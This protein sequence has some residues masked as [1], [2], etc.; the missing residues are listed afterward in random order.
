MFESLAKTDFLD[1]LSF[2]LLTGLLFAIVF[3]RYLFISGVFHFVFYWA[4]RNEFENRLINGDIKNKSQ[5][6]SEIKWS[7][8]TSFLFAVSGTVMVILWQSDN[9]ALYI[10]INEYPLWYLPISLTIALFLHETYYYWL[11]RWMH[12]PKVYRVMHKVHH[13][14]VET[15]SLTSFSFHPLESVLQAIIIP[16]IVFLLPMNIYVLLVILVIMTISGTLNHAGVELYPH[17]FHK[18]W[19]GKWLI[20]ATHHDLHH[21]KFRCNYGL[22]FTFWDKWMGTES[23]DFQIKIKQKT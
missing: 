9:T 15:T 16:L 7:A 20:G 12:I 4:F 8:I 23:E 19:L 13:D 22:Y 17:N 5:V 18:H 2:S 21:K 10:E 14:S 3:L 11:H 1:P 6:I